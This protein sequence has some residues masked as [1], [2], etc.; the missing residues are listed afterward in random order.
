MHRRT[1][2]LAILGMLVLGCMVA[3]AAPAGA[4]AA[5]GHSRVPVKIE[6]LAQLTGPDMSAGTFTSRVGR[7]KDSGTYTETFTIV[8][9]VID[10]EKVLTGSRGTIVMHVRG[11]VDNPTPTTVA[12]R[13][14]R[15]RFVSGT[16][17]YCG[18]EGGGRPGA[19]GGADLATG[20]IE[21]SHRGTA[22]LGRT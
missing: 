22:R 18:L 8:D 1:A 19:I 11:F 13:G 9:G 14:G 20:A 10:A 12:F 15:W 3:A 5:T 21:V 2:R 16:G 7:V 6:M 17:T 4:T